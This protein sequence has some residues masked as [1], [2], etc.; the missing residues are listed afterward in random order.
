M[1]DIPAAFVEVESS[2]SDEDGVLNESR[3]LSSSS[4]PAAQSHP[5][6]ASLNQAGYFLP[7]LRRRYGS[8]YAQLLRFDY[9]GAL[10]MA[11]LALLGI[12]SGLI[13]W[14]LDESVLLLRSVTRSSSAQFQGHEYAGF[15]AWST[16]LAVS[17]VMVTRQAPAAAGSGIPEMR[18]ILCGFSIPDFFDAKTAL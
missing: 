14:T 17:A 2:D 13:A 9:E 1:K 16:F 18:S 15:I 4:S 8:K 6:H 3:S 7:Y 12:I 11:L 5:S 10:S